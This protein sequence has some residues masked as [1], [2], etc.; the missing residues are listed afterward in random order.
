MKKDL[1]LSQTLKDGC[2]AIDIENP[3]P[4][5]LDG[6]TLYCDLP[7]KTRITVNGREAGGL[8]LNPPD[9]T[10]RPS[11]SFPWKRLEFPVI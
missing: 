4:N 1:R 10:G 5:S 9:H 6:L 3:H 11:I 7:K 2:T 8:R